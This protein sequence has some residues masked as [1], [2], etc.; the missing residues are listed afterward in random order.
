MEWRRE[1]GGAKQDAGGT[2]DN[3]PHALDVRV[4]LRRVG[5]SE[6]ELDLAS[7]KE[8]SE[9]VRDESG[10]LVGPNHGGF[11]GGGEVHFCG[12]IGGE[13][14][15]GGGGNNG[16]GPMTREDAAIAGAGVDDATIVY[17][18]VK[19]T[20]GEGTGKVHVKDGAGRWLCGQGAGRM[21]WSGA[22]AATKDGVANRDGGR[23]D[24]V[25]RK[26]MAI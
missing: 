8:L 4:L 18:A 15:K 22:S 11:E 10:T 23:R 2:E 7:V 20:S 5:A 12:D 17:V 26:A 3:A 6:G 9:M 13:G 1:V 25:G 14:G 21:E 16:G 19:E 24:G